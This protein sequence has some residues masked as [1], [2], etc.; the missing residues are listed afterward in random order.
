[1]TMPGPRRSGSTPLRTGMLLVED[2]ARIRQALSLALAD[3]GFDIMEAATGEQ[4]L[5]R[6]TLATSIWSCSM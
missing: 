4:A 1:M 3:V 2:D 5:H 6:W